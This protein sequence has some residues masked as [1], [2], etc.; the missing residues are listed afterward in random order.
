MYRVIIVED[1]FIVRFGIRSMIDWEKVGLQVAGEAANG[2]EALELIRQNPPDILITDIKMPVMD[3]IALIEEVRS[4]GYT[5]KIIIL[6]NLDEFHYAQ[7]AIRHGVSEYLIKSDMMPRDFEQALMNVKND[8]DLKGDGGAAN[9]QASKL[10]PARKEKLLLRLI[11][12][13]LLDEEELAALQ[14]LR[15]PACLLHLLIKT[16]EHGFV[17]RQQ[18]IQHALQGIGADNA[19]NIVLFADQAGGMNVLLPLPAGVASGT[20]EGWARRQAERI[21]AYLA[22]QDGLVCTIGVSGTISHWEQMSQAYKQATAAARQ[23]MFQGIGKVIAYSGLAE[24]KEMSLEPIKVNSAQIHA[25]LYAFQTKELRDYVAGLFDQLA[26]RQDPDLAQIISFELLMILTGVWP[27]VSN[28]QQH[29][30][31]LKKQYFDQLSRLETVEQSSEF[32]IQAFGDLQQHMIHIYNSDR[33]SIIKA[34]QYIQQHYHQDISLQSMSNFVHLSK[35]YFANLFKK[36]VG[37]SFLEYVTN[38]RIE[39]AKALLAGDMKA[40]DVGMMVGIQDPKY[41]SKVFKKIAGVS[42]SEYR[43]LVKEDK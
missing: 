38:V 19:A 28:D 16:T 25:F 22:D 6:S 2:R 27:E 41:F 3:G 7:R 37:E 24:A 1:E 18:L 4:S 17:E 15:A 29:V 32:F 12:G 30:L 33:N 9:G 14:E 42:P 21:V 5:M 36:E 10:Q 23:S 43:S 40:A 35:N 34:T 26:S 8:L 13:V 39:K 11:E 20:S 31:Q